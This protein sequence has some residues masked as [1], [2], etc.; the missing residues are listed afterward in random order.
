MEAVRTHYAVLRH[1]P[2]T[3]RSVGDGLQELIIPFGDSGYLAQYSYEPDED[4]VYILAFRH[5][6]EE[7]Y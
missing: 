6:R 1:T 7:D 2:E 4:T 5:R 3:G